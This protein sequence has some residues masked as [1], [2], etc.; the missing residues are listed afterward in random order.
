MTPPKYTTE[1]PG[2]DR[3]MDDGGAA[4]WRRHDQARLREPRWTQGQHQPRHPR[5]TGGVVACDGSVGVHACVSVGTRGRRFPPPCRCRARLRA[6]HTTART[7]RLLHCGAASNHSCRHALCTTTTNL[8]LYLQTS[9]PRDLAG[10]MSLNPDHCW[11][12]VRALVDMLLKQPEGES[13]V[14]GCQCRVSGGVC[15]RGHRARAGHA[16]AGG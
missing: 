7:H 2:Q 4:G 8:L 3:Q 1:Q 11:G 5:H 15:A 6:H 16:A 12:I 10:Q 13:R 14:V 9:K